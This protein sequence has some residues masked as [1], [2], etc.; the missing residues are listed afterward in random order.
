MIVMEKAD[1]E[2]A[3]NHLKNLANRMYKQMQDKLL[4]IIFKIISMNKGYFI[5]CRRW[6]I[7][8]FENSD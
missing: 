4:P 1:F 2:M 3:I 7:V 6:I 5:I 8:L